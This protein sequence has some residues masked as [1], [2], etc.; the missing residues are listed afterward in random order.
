MAIVSITEI[1]LDQDIPPEVDRQF[2]EGAL[3][4]MVPTSAVD[5]KYVGFQN[6]KLKKHCPH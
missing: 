3:A 5:I 6:R 4:K 1:H 2:K